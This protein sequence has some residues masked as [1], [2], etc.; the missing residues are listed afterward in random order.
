MSDGPYGRHGFSSNT[1]YGG[2][3]GGASYGSQSGGG[4]YSAPSYGQNYGAGASYGGAGGQDYGSQYGS[5][6]GSTP[7]NYAGGNEKDDG[8]KAG[9]KSLAVHALNMY[10]FMWAGFLSC[11]LFAY[12]FF[13]GGDFSFLMTYGGM[14]RTFGFG[15]LCLKTF[16]S[17]RATGVS[18]KTLQLYCLVFFFRLTSIIR[19]EGYLPY[20]KSGDWLYHFVEG[21][22][23]CLCGLALYAC[24]GPFKHTYQADLDKFGEMGV[25]PGAGAI[26]LAGPILILAILVH[27]NLNADF[28]SDTAW[29]YAMYLESAAVLPQ[30]YMFNKQTSGVVE[31]LTTLCIRSRVWARHGI[32]LLDLQLP[33]A[34]RCVWIEVARLLGPL[35]PIDSTYHDD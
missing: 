26:F 22:A 34:C 12:K 17:Q 23:L 21:T 8:K 1:G 33:R 14:A 10:V 25:P 11:S 7:D 5:Y 32:S 15:V 13:S 4:G 20:D 16:K 19:H 6:G 29:T 35:F 30:L 31:L 24:M 27:P 18:V 28:I 9:K 3:A 2:Q